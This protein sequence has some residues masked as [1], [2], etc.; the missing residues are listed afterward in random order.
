MLGNLLAIIEKSVAP[1]KE[2]DPVKILQGYN[3]AQGSESGGNSHGGSGA[4]GVVNG[5]LNYRMQKPLVD[6]V[7]QELGLVNEGE[8]LREL[9]TQSN[10]SITS[11]DVTKTDA[12]LTDTVKD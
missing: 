2:V 1:I 5:L 11:T 9:V 4:D 10:L 7:L 3:T 12:K 6:S 8:G